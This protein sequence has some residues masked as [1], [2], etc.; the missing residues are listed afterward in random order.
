MN[1]ILTVSQLKW[2]SNKSRI[3]LKNHRNL[4]APSLVAVTVICLIFDLGSGLLGFSV[5]NE[6]EDS[7]YQS[8]SKHLPCK[9]HHYRL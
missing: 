3:F 2:V 6:I 4:E 9:N 5:A 1:L 8:L 7:N